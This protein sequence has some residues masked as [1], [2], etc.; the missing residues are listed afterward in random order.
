MLCALADHRATRRDDI[1]LG[2]LP[3]ARVRVGQPPLLA[4]GCHTRTVIG[5]GYLVSY[6]IAARALT[7]T[8]AFGVPHPVFAS[9]PV[10][11]G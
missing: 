2:S 1:C 9:Y 4:A 8:G 5:V 10:V 11:V 7:N 6:G 3:Q